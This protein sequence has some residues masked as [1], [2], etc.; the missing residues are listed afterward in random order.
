MQ[1]LALVSGLIGALLSA[2][3]AFLI[4]FHLD[5]MA[6]RDGER[7]LAY[8]YLV[9]VS[10]SVA[11]GIVVQS[12]AK[13]YFGELVA[14]HFTPPDQSFTPSHAVSAFIA[15]AIVD[16]ANQ[17]P[18]AMPRAQIL[19]KTIEIALDAAKETRLSADQ[20]SRMPPGTVLLSHQYQSALQ[21]LCAALEV[22]G[23]LLTSEDRSWITAS[24]VHNHWRGVVGFA[25]TARRLRSALIEY[26]ASSK[27]DADRLLLTQAQEIHANFAASLEDKAKLEPAAALARKF[28][29]SESGT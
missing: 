20:L 17:A 2:L 8:V 29:E 21:N 5:K 10:E 4:R 16:G 23:T 3:L 7:R 11:T 27:Q 24:T 15:Q 14:K 6:Q 12:F 25:Q 13:A 22:W 18:P 1:T 9:R 26:G 19:M 28:L